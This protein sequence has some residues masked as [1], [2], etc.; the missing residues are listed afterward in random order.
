MDLSLCLG[1][2]KVN[3]PVAYIEKEEREKKAENKTLSKVEIQA[4]EEKEEKKMGLRERWKT[5]VQ[6]LK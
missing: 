1:P 2:D 5:S 3:D 4:E 6:D